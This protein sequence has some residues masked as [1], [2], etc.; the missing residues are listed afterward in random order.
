MERRTVILFSIQMLWYYFQIDK[1][2]DMSAAVRT[3]TDILHTITQPVSKISFSGMLLLIP[4]YLWKD[5]KWHSFDSLCS[6]GTW[7][8]KFLILMQI[9]RQNSKT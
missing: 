1:I 9:I 5:L 7:F 4:K 2:D 3:Q 6:Y 8:K